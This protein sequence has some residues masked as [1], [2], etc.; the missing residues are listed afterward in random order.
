MTAT[1]TNT[2]NNMKQSDGFADH[3]KLVEL[4]RNINSACDIALYQATSQQH[5]LMKYNVVLPSG[6]RLSY[7]GLH[8]D[9]QKVINAQIMGEGVVVIKVTLLAAGFVVGTK[10]R[11]IHQISSDTGASIKSWT[12]Y[13]NTGEN[14]K[15]LRA[16]K[17][18][19]STSSILKTMQIITT[20]VNR[21]KELTEGEFTGQSVNRD[22]VIEGIYSTRQ[23]TILLRL[24]MAR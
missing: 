13:Y 3:R 1:N 18:S 11:S 2:T 21:Y 24:A 14:Q 23:N 22:Q 10:G 4:V 8:E 7:E 16:F 17:I 5:D 20:A 19:G 6:P 12:L 9:E 15:A